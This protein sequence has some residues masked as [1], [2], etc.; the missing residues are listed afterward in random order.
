MATDEEAQNLPTVTLAALYGAG[1]T[2]VGRRVAEALGVRLLDREIPAAV[3]DRLGLTETMVDE[4]EEEPESVSGRMLRRLGSA[5][6]A[7]ANAAQAGGEIELQER[8]LRGYI[9]EFMARSTAEGGVMVGRGGMVVLRSLPWALH[10]YL[11]GP[12]EARIKQGMKLEE[13][14]RER[15]EQRLE[16]EDRIR[17][18]YVQR[19]YGIDGRDSNLYHLTLDSTALELDLCVELI[20]AAAR[21]RVARPSRT[22]AV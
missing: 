21:D 14:D 6:T 9:E 10:V 20:V 7:T 11:R 1:G 13:I 18:G 2:Y 4:A 17:I 3:A 12:R 16:A 15:A 22:Q 8:R 5:G 19:A